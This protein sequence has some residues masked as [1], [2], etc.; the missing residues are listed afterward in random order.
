MRLYFCIKFVMAGEW[1]AHVSVGPHASDLMTR[2]TGRTTK[3]GKQ[4]ATQAKKV[5][6]S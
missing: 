2:Q 5:S 1:Q 3:T 6:N 4:W